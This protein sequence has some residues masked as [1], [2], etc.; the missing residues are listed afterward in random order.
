MQALRFLVMNGAL[1]VVL[2]S[3]LAGG[4]WLWTG[5]IAL[6][7]ALAFM[8]ELMG[9]GAEP[10]G[11]AR[12]DPQDMLLYAAL[13]LLLV[14]TALYATYLSDRDPFGLFALIDQTTGLDLAT[15]RQTTSPFHMIGGGL[16]I[17]SVYAAAGAVVAHEFVHRLGRPVD[18]VQGYLLLGLMAD[19][20]YAV[21]H[22]F[23]HHRNV[24]DPNDPATARRG[25]HFYRF[26]VRSA[27]GQFREAFVLEAARRRRRG[28][29]PSGIDSPVLLGLAVS[30]AYGAAF[31]Y[32]AGWTGIAVFAALA[33]GG[34]IGHQAANYVQH[35]G[36]ARAEGEPVAAHHSWDS[37]R[38]ASNAL[39]YNVPRHADHH[40]HMGRPYHRLERREDAPQLPFGYGIM[41]MLCYVP[42]LWNRV[43][44]RPLAEWDARFGNT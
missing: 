16:S 27:G 5:A 1:L 17:A 2:A 35:Y 24:G 32:A 36:L 44:A 11:E 25:E 13:P 14:I 42:P 39:L 30:L 21:S 26:A 7:T 3:L 18:M 4:I 28:R 6:T 33:A 12:T 20:T 23:G 34:K 19:T 9:D 29:P 31:A 22:V 15:S 10:K 41:L 37:Y 43:M 38:T 8:D 40:L